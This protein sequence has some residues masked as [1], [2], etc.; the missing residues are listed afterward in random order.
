MVGLTRSNF[1]NIRQRDYASRRGYIENRSKI[2]S[3]PIN[4]FWTQEKYTIELAIESDQVN[5]LVKDNSTQTG[6]SPSERSDGLQWL[7][8]FYISFSAGM[9][10]E[11]KSAIIL[12]DN[13]AA[14]LHM[15]GQRDLLRIIEN[16][17][18]K[19]NNQIFYVTH[20]PALVD[21]ARLERARLVVKEDS[22]G[23]KIRPYLYGTTDTLEPIRSAIGCS[24]SNSLFSGRKTILVEG[25]GDYYI[26]NAMNRWL[27]KQG[28]DRLDHD[29]VIPLP[30]TNWMAFIML[31]RA[32]KC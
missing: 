4:E 5:V 27:A 13:P 26:L 25:M 1:E 8:S 29:T 14:E 10:G 20:S 28:R 21:L 31:I 23:T 3:G 12:L 32:P 11:L 16:Q 19:G 18:V 15:D 9:G 24:I 6:T 7:L 22:H 17:F 2:I 30:S